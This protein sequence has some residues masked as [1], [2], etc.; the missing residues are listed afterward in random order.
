MDLYE[1]QSRE[2]R[3]QHKLRDDPGVLDL[4]RLWF[5]INMVQAGLHPRPFVSEEDLGDG[6]APL[7]EM[8][9]VQNEFESKY[10]QVRDIIE[11]YGDR[12]VLS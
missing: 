9:I 11:K 3:D 7:S 12:V 1:A 10:K 2:W 8:A 4:Y 6:Y 5:K